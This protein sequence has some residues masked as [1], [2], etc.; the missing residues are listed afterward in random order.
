MNAA[1]CFKFSYL[2]QMVQ[3]HHQ[4]NKAKKLLC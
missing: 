4:Y 3:K 1:A 2:Q